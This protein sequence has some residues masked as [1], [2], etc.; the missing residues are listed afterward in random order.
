M[1]TNFPVHPLNDTVDGPTVTS[2]L[3][4]LMLATSE[5]MQRVVI[6]Q[7]TARG[8]FICVLGYTRG[9]MQSVDSFVF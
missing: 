9:V 5:C 6:K 1:I 2:P 7:C 8:Y 4:M 3:D